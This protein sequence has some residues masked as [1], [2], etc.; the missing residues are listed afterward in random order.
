MRLVRVAV[1]VPAL[2][3]L[4]YCV[5]DEFPMPPI[6]ARVLVPLGSRVMTGCVLDHVPGSVV[7]GSW[8]VKRDS[9]DPAVSEPSP[10]ADIKQVIDILDSTP[11]LPADIVKLTTWVSEYYAAGVG[12]AMAAAMPPRAWI[13]SERYAQITDVG[14]AR[15]LTE[16]GSRRDILEALV[17]D[18]P[19]RVDGLGGARKGSHAVLAGLE[20]DGLIALTKPLKGAAAAFRTVR[21]A[22]LTVQGHE[23]A[24]RDAADE[25]TIRL[26]TKQ[27]EALALLMGAPEGLETSQL[28]ERG[29]GGPTL[30]RLSTV[31]LVS[32]SRRRVDRDPFE[33]AAQPVPPR[34]PVELTSEQATAF[35]RLGGLVASQ[36]FHAALLHGVTGSGKTEIY[37]RLADAV[38][39]QGRS[40]LLLVP[41]IALTPSVA[42]IFR[43]AFG[44][45]VAIQ[46]SGLSDGER[47]DQWHRIRRGDVD[48]VVGTRSA[49]F[50]PLRSL[51]LIVVDEEHDGSY[52]QEETPRYNGRD[53]A[54]MRAR[55]AGALVVLG[56][57]TPSMES[58]QNALSSRYTL[59][60]LERR[61]LDRPL[62][63][64]RIV[65]M[66]EEYAA[67]GPDVILSGALCD[68]LAE[69]LDLRE[70][71]IVLLNRRGYASS[72]FCRQ[73]AATLECPNCSVSLTVHRAAR[74]A[75]CHYC[76]YSMALPKACLNCAGP[77]L[78]QLGFGTE[79]VEAEIVA[80]FPGARVARVDRDTIRKRGAI[81]GLLSRFAAGE[82]D[83]LVGTQMIAKGHDFPRVS[84]VG[85]ISADVGLGLADFRAAERTFQLLTQVAGR[86][87]RGEIRGQAIVQ[88]L[89]PD[90]YS[91]R[92]ACKQDYVAFF[93]D[94]ANF[95]RAMHYPPS[96]ALVN[97]VVKGRSMASAMQDA[98]G[99]VQAL[100]S[101]KDSYRVLGPATAPLSRIKGEHR[102]QLFLKG[103]HR[104]AMREALVAV[105][106]E[107]P[108]LRRRT[109]VDIDPMSVL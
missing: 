39:Q 60:T 70:Q 22:S 83:I 42:G 36:Q 99:I 17:D 2:D 109:I 54:V 91:I 88:T 85:V 98:G 34:P 29:I 79:R 1:P 8:F 40:V 52:K 4:T 25:S 53:V 15:M 30:S 45:R 71:A 41:E 101:R 62:A 11:F 38:R 102:A 84:L 97:V 21:V 77:F 106:E 107:R 49:V 37:L 14:H 61:V 65:D 103:T 75:R 18:K 94:E 72:V 63:E 19:V 90:H 9:N 55:Q 66:R 3:S 31:G 92:H 51:G 50:A 100:R 104:T 80:R 64:V 89:Y 95:R 96:V 73:C 43:A 82:L 57:A 56:S 16:R 81:A 32:L 69:R 20:R 46:H 87:G 24:G 47:Y 93:S 68:A 78:E 5:P 27:R 108:E 23:I 76:N 86:A 67:A 7:R 33:Q 6:G 35:E 58:Y 13:E 48:V 12:E 59:V 44:E 74:R 105:L 26:G 10:T 28:F